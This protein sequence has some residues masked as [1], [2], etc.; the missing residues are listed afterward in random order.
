MD[1]GGRTVSVVLD[2]N[3]SKGTHVERMDR[4]VSGIVLVRLD[5]RTIGTTVLLP[6][7]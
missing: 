5:G 7:R 6:T 4:R 1:A 2:R 3:L